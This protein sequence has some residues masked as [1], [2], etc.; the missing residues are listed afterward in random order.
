LAVAD[1]IGP[2]VQ[3]S[4]DHVVDPQIGRNRVIEILL[5]VAPGSTTAATP[6]VCSPLRHDACERHSR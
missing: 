6:V 4:L 2:G 3:A 1:E 5:H